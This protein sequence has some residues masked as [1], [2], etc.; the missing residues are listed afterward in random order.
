MMTRM[1]SRAPTI[2]ERHLAGEVSPARATP[3]DAFTLAQRAFEAGERVDM[4]AIASEL[5]VSR[6]TLYRWAG[7][8]E[9]LLGEVLWARLGRTLERVIADAGERA[10]RV[11][12][13]LARG[14]E[15]IAHDRALAR[16][17]ERD[18]EFALRVLTTKESQVQRRTI[19]AL[20]ELLTEDVAAG[21]LEPAMDVDTLAYVL[22][23]IGESFLYSDVITGEPVDAGK[24]ADAFRA[25]L[26]P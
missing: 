8:K 14:T 24:A 18:P 20:V 26:R 22:V 17:L 9:L 15:L 6:T 12:T 2:L 1:A 23:R 21:R 5:G 10:D 11:A 19:A 3:R 7:S 25:V 16:F 13:I 4:H